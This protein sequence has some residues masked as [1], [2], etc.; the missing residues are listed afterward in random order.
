MKAFIFSVLLLSVGVASDRSL[1]DRAT[2]AVSSAGN[3]TG[4]MSGG[5]SPQELQSF[6]SLE[7]IDTHTH[8]RRSDPRFDAMLNRL[9]V[10]VLDIILVDDRNPEENDLRAE[11]DAALNFIRGSRRARSFVHLFR[12]IQDGAAG[13]CRNGHSR[14]Q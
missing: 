10:H 8:V 5:F 9:N 3:E 14:A 6:T 2:L 4:V 11:R 12:P 7:P 13:I 1:P